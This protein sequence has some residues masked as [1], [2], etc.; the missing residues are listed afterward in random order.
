MPRTTAVTARDDDLPLE[1]EADP[2]VSL[3]A[4]AA[5]SVLDLGRSPL[6]LS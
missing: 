5:T 1:R 2:P 4:G 3:T 6:K